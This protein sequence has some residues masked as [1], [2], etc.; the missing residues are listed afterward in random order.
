MSPT[1]AQLPAGG[2]PPP[3]RSSHACAA[4]GGKVYFFGGEAQPRIP[5]ANDTYCYDLKERAWSKLATSG[6]P[7]CARMGCTAA[8][9]GADMYIFGGRSGI[10]MGEGSLHDLHALDTAML[11]W[12]LVEPAAGSPPPPGARSYHTMAAVGSRLYVFGGCGAGGRLN[13]LHW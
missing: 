6:E 12:R 3:P 1:W 9:V 10:E 11:T 2:T 5:V 4:V 8:A 7:P 13:D